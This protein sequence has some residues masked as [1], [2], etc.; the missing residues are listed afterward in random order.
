MTPHTCEDLDVAMCSD[1][2]RDVV[3]IA[4]N[5]RQ[6]GVRLLELAPDDAL[7]VAVRL[8]V[9]AREAQNLQKWGE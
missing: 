4:D 1:D 8:I 7:D 9:A 3:V 6:P 2:G 5:R